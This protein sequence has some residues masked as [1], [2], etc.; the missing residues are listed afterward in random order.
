MRVCVC[1]YVLTS[2]IPMASHV[3][4][5]TSHTTC[6]NV[7]VRQWAQIGMTFWLI[8]M[9]KAPMIRMYES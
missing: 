9:E 5:H 6:A 3:T 4:R 8:I 7:K 1:M 2:A